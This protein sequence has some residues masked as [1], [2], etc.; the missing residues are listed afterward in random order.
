MVN[1]FMKRGDKATIPGTEIYFYFSVGKTVIFNLS[2]TFK[3]KWV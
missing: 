2:T 1:D 3:Y